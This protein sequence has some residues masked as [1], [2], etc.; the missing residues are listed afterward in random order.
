[1]GLEAPPLQRSPSLGRLGGLRN[2]QG[3]LALQMLECENAEVAWF[4]EVLGTLED[5]SSSLAPRD[6]KKPYELNRL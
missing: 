3:F 1:M 4:L 6:V 5:I 2:C